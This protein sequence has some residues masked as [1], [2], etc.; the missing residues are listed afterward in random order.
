MIKDIKNNVICNEDTEYTIL[1]FWAPWCGPCRMMK[2]VVE[3]LFEDSNFGNVSFQRVNVDENPLLSNYHHV[4][5]IPTL[6]VLKGDT[7]VETL[8]GFKPKNKLMEELN[9]VLI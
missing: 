1:Q 8:V 5:S 6:L 3:E 9:Q 2:P 4:Q 7:L